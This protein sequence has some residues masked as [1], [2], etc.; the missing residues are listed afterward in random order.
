[1]GM[2]NVL[3]LPFLATSMESSI[4]GTS[5]RTKLPLRSVTVLMSV[6][7]TVTVALST[8]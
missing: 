7:F 8:G 6:P 5:S 3:D 4:K 1:M 2:G